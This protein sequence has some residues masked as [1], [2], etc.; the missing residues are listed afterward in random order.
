MQLAISDYV[1]LA[2]LAF[3]IAFQ[4][5]HRRMPPG[6][7]TSVFVGAVSV[8]A[9]LAA[10]VH[11]GPAPWNLY[12]TCHVSATLCVLWSFLGWLA[13]QTAAPAP[14]PTTAST[15]FAWSLVSG[16]GT[17]VLTVN[18]LTT[19]TWI[20]VLDVPQST[21]MIAEWVGIWDI[22][23]MLVAVLI[24]AAVGFRSQQPV[25]LLILVALAVWWSS[26]RVSPVVGSLQYAHAAIPWFKPVWWNWIFQMQL[27]LTTVL[28]AAAVLQDLR[29]RARRNR[30]WPDRLD[31]L[32]EPYSRWPVF[33][34]VEALIASVILVLGVYQ[35]VQFAPP[36]WP[37]SLASCGVSAVAGTTCVF[38]TYRR[39]SANTAGLGLA[40][41]SLSS[42]LLS[43]AVAAVTIT[44][45]ESTEY[46]ERVPA[47]FN[48]V[49]FA[50]VVMIALWRWLAIVW[51]QQLLGDVPWTTAG[52]MIPCNRRAA[53]ILT[54]LAMLLAFEM[55][56]WPR[57]V[58]AS[59]ADDT[60]GRIIAGLLAIGLLAWMTMRVAIR[61]N[62]NSHA[63][64]AVA[65]A[66]AAL[67]FYF[68]RMPAPAVR[69][70]VVQYLAV[71]LGAL[72]VPALLA[73]ESLSKH[74]WRSFAAPLWLLALLVLPLLSMADLLSSEPLP[75]QWVK[76]A[77]LAILGVVYGLAG[78]REH[79]RA[80][81][82]L[83]G[84][85]FLAS[86]TTLY[87]IY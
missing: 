19:L 37:L 27:G 21:V 12:T 64:L 22:A 2:L 14:S 36:G 62:S 13:H 32:L 38:M 58:P 68:I 87:R 30:A 76:P 33:I 23:A 77:A 74:R 43:C 65:L 20:R 85:L 9:A 49:L 44:P 24:W 78:R 71:V 48:A 31:D 50:L 54:A 66:I 6:L 17:A 82:V 45:R 39:W 56:M 5:F 57:L 61:D 70:W 86:G 34:Q 10:Y 8:G 83:G 7:G 84:V 80:F 41:L 15:F 67:I 59:N 52:R 72:A 69:G 3:G 42:V 4:L 26:L 63:T 29:Y 73:A 16:I 81:L 18:H 1:A 46:A 47:L 75:A 25:L 28:A 35:V 40:L 60:T 11:R 53:F 55:A 79:R 51:H